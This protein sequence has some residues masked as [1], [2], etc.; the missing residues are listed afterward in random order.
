MSR[1]CADCA[2]LPETLAIIVDGSSDDMVQRLVFYGLV[3]NSG[4]L[5]HYPRKLGRIQALLRGAIEEAK[6]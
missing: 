4:A 6:R 1:Q 5:T 3:D 2:V